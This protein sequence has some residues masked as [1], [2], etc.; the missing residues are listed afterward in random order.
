[1]NKFMGMA[2]ILA[3]LSSLA[4]ANNARA[5]S[6]D[7]FQI[8]NIEY[9][10]S[11]CPPGTATVDPIGSNAF[12]VTYDT[13]QSQLGEGIP[14]TPR[15]SA[16]SSSTC[17]TRQA[18]NSRVATSCIAAMPICSPTSSPG[19]APATRSRVN[20]RYPLKHGSSGLSWAISA[21][22]M[23]SINWRG[24]LA[25]EMPRSLPPAPRSSFPTIRGPRAS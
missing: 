2:G 16:I 9:R 17:V 21:F 14:L 12:L 19:S 11:A 4:F 3:G 10:G 18:T 1:M 13:F 6:P 20:D 7:F 24:H 8:Q 25:A 23:P 5:D 22:P 15:S